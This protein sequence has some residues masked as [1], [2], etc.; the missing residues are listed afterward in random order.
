MSFCSVYRNFFNEEFYTFGMDW[1]E[2]EIITWIKTR[3]HTVMV[4]KSPKKG[5]FD[6]G[7]FPTRYGNGTFVE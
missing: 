3:A 5:F 7:N 6:I 2:N 1:D 4:Q